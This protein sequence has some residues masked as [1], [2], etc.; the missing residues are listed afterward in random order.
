MR[1]F[2]SSSFRRRFCYCVTNQTNDLT[3]EKLTSGTSGQGQG[4]NRQ[5]LFVC[6]LYRHTAGRDGELH[7]LCPRALQISVHPIR[8][9]GLKCHVFLELPAAV[10]KMGLVCV[11]VS[12]S[13]RNQSTCTYICVMAGRTG[14]Y[15]RNHACFLL[16][17][18]SGNMSFSSRTCWL[19]SR[20]RGAGAVG[21]PLHHSPLQPDH[22]GRAA[23]RWATEA[24]RVHLD[25]EA[26][27][28]SFPDVTSTNSDTDNKH[29]ATVGAHA[30]ADT[31]TNPGSS[32]W[33]GTS[34]SD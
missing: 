26:N 11:C 23:A 33:T 10:L 20:S 28:L 1:S 32:S 25:A 4:Y 16:S 30:P 24:A 34:T 21:A 18:T 2:S 8:W 7:H 17:G 29:Q 3:G 22:R 6:R 15:H 5:R 12:V 19:S 9:A 31:R 27:L 13:Q 14:Q